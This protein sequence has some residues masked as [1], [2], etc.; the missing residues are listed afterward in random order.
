MAKH[1]LRFASYKKPNDIFE[2]VKSGEKTLETR[3]ISTSKNFKKGDELVLVS[4]DTKEN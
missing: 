2:A 3:P 1:I 4:L